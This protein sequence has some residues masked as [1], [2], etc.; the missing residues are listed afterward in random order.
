MET[1]G[2]MGP[3]VMGQGARG[4]SGQGGATIMATP[5]LSL[6]RTQNLK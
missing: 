5:L 3:C 2:A 6:G 1:E 4:G